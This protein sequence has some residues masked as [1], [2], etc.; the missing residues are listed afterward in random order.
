MEESIR[1]TSAQKS[2]LIIE[3][4]RKEIL[5]GLSILLMVAIVFLFL[6]LLLKLFGA[7]PETFIVGFIYFISNI[8]LLP[9]FGIFPHADD[10]LPGRSAIDTTALFAIFC[11]LILIP[12]A[13]AVV[14]LGAMIMKTGKQVNETVD[15]K[16]TVDATLVE[17]SIE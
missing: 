15:Q 16:K 14:Q 7:N 4:M 8:F 5:R 9:Y 10:L 13:M 2:L 6:R 1:I 12:L 17:D 3:A 11:Y